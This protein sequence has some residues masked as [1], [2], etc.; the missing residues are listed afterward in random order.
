MLTMVRS[1][2]ITGSPTAM[3]ANWYLATS[4]AGGYL[5]GPGADF[6]GQSLL[7]V[8]FSPVGASGD[9][10][11]ADFAGVTVQGQL[12][13]L[14][15]AGANFTGA[16]LRG[17]SFYGSDLTGADFSNADLTGGNLSVTTL[18]GTVLGS[19]TL[20]SVA[21]WGLTGAPA[22]LPTNWSLRDNCLIGPGA[23]LAGASLTGADLAHADLADANLTGALMA[24]SD[25][26]GTDLAGA[27]LA[28]AD[29]TDAN[30]TSANLAG[31]T[32]TGTLL[33]G[34]IW[35]DT[36]CPDGTNSDKHV[37]GCL[38]KL[39][40]TPPAVTVTGVR[41]RR[42]VLGAVPRPGCAT[43]DDGAVARPAT[44][45]VTTSGA[46]HVGRFTATCSGAVDLAGN[47]QAAPVSVSYT[48]VYGFGVY[49]APGRGSTIRKA[50]R[51]LVVR[52]RLTGAGGRP[53]ART[54]GASLAARHAVR[55]RLAGPGIRPRIAACGWD[56]ARA[57]FRCV[58]AIPAG[59]R[60]G[61]SRRY[62]LTASENVGTGFLIAPPVG[63]AVNPEV[64]HFR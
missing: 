47:K 39:D 45:T 56:A 57:G 62:T 46:H 33:S 30:L 28:G 38:S 27:D 22:S 60:T 59:A 24:S 21:A 63:K 7:G 40:T 49:T 2:G 52:F 41:S 34:V 25:L 51:R 19:A 44:L 31:A 16:S 50:S 15:L 37:D 64:I 3:P 48:V 43:T 4:V 61:L 20:T 6:S 26:T 17:V 12:G 42:Y 54:I 8:D 18:T 23:V 13:G 5:A 10:A 35:S 36:T 53:I 14:N 11:S 55:V 58:I 29:L 32:V 1:G 9:L